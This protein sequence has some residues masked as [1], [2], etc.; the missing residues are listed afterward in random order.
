MANTTDV[1]GGLFNALGGGAMAG[2]LGSFASPIAAAGLIGGG[3]LEFLGAEQEMKAAKE[4]SSDSAVIAGY[5]EQINEVKRTQ[6]N[7]QTNRQEMENLRNTQRA[8][9]TGRAAATNQGVASGTG[10]GTSSGLA[11]GRAADVTAGAVNT[12]NLVANQYLGN[13]VFD[14]TSS[15]DQYKQKIAL[16]QGSEATGA[17]LASLGQ[18]IMGSS[19]NLG[20]LFA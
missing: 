4:I 6:M 15:I 7:V 17:G 8:V 5:E 14:L 2:G 13:K 11:G 10:A 1:T 18:G 19:L 3:V 12:Q 9:A 20:K 16:A